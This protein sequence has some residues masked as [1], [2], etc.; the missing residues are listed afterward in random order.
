ESLV[1]VSIPASVK[2][3]GGYAFSNCTSLVSIGV[4]SNN[5]R[6]ATLDGVL[7]NKKM[8][9]LVQYPAGNQRSAYTV[10]A[11]VT[12]I[13]VA[14]FAYC[15]NL[16]AIEVDGANASYASDNGVLYNADMSTLIQYPVGNHNTSFA[17]PD[18]VTAIADYSFYNCTFLADITL[19]DSVASIGVYAFDN[20]AY[21]NNTANWDGNVLYI[22]NHLIKAKT[23]LSGSYTVK[24]GTVTVADYAF[25]SCSKLTNIVLDNS[26][27][28]IGT[29]I[30]AHCTALE[31]VTIGTGAV[32]IGNY[33]F[34]KCTA[35]TDVYYNSTEEDWAVIKVGIG[36][37]CLSA[38]TIH[39]TVPVIVEGVCGDDLT[40]VF[41]SVEGTLTISGTGEMYDYS[42]EYVG[43]ILRTTAPWKAY[44]ASVRSI[45][46]GDDVTSIGDYAFYNFES[47]SD[48][49]LDGSVTRIGNGAFEKCV[50]L[51]N[52]VI[53]DSVVTVGDTAFSGCVF[54]SSL[55]IGDSVTAIGDSAFEG[56]VSLKNVNLGSSVETVGAKA[57]K[58]CE[59]LAGISIPASLKTVGADA[60]VGCNALAGVYITD[61]AAWCGIGFNSEKSNPLTYAKKL[62][63][64]STFV[65][66]L[67]IPSSVKN[68]NNYA[69]YNC[70]S[71][72]TVNFGTSVKTIGSY[73]FY[74]CTGLGELT[75]PASVTAIGEKAF[76][77]YMGGYRNLDITIVCVENSYAHTY[78]QNNGFKYKIYGSCGDNLTWTFV[79]STGTLTILGEGDMYNY[80]N[81]VAPWAS[82]ASSVKS[83][84]IGNGVT[85]IG[86]Y[87]FMGCDALTSVNIPASVAKLG[88]GA[89]YE[90][91]ALKSVAIPES[92]ETI[93][94]Y[95]FYGCTSLVKVTLPVSVTTVGY[96]AFY[97][98]TSLAD[99]YYSGLATQWAEIFIDEYN[100]A[101]T[102]ANLHFLSP[103]IARGDCGDGVVWTLNEDGVL[104]VSGEGKMTDYTSESYNG[105][106]RTT[107]PWKI[108]ASSIK[109]VV[110]ESGVES[111]GTSAFCYCPGLESV[112]VADTVVSVGEDAFSNCTSLK[113]ITL[114]VSIRA[115]GN[116]AFYNTAYYNTNANWT[117]NVLYIGRHLIKAN[118][119]ISGTCYINSGTVTIAN[120][121]FA[122]CQSLTGVS[123]PSSVITIG[124]NAFAGCVSLGKVVIPNSVTRVGNSAFLDCAS[125]DSVTIG[126]SV[127]YIGSSAFAYCYSLTSISI[128]D[129]VTTIGDNAFEECSELADITLPDSLTSIGENA[130][131]Y[132]AYFNDS[133]NW[134]SQ[135]LYIGNHLI[136]AKR[137]LK[138]SYYIKDGTLTIADSA[139][140]GC[141]LLT[142]VTMPESVRDIGKKAFFNCTTFADVSYGGSEEQW[143]AIRIGEDNDPLNSAN[144]KYAS[145][146]L[147]GDDVTWS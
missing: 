76:Q 34:Y 86:D 8:T 80:E 140:Y 112:T 10:P 129:S 97:D 42:N 6:Y 57:F 132:T 122:N 11:S 54:L 51:K 3:I 64:D 53:G 5:Q 116:N 19:P 127:D 114:P 31:N 28:N 126:T 1:S 25:S 133:S 59:S 55:N 48:I 92:V 24:S 100:E 110:I 104:T 99:V 27:V 26:V 128:P 32:S 62:Y 94:Y 130:F 134:E 144:I 15:S 67:V 84:V 137:A 108:Y 102:S 13:G 33:A 139:F 85:G 88:A 18:S 4:D 120:N 45:F 66:D 115:I 142:S 121:A 65:T 16:E 109:S 103:I 39:Y 17:V 125:L 9:T 72:K 98:C 119:P 69:F 30:F 73:A 145:S 138:S 101:L 93:D 56:C 37:E 96:A 124:D 14:A 83:V 70:S 35:L 147:C 38:S 136:K 118:L 105:T 71:L 123:I 49:T 89:F 131:N 44:T 43:G 135:V 40:W 46:I 107:A 143:L 79:S 47:V 91:T 75:I 81:A 146:K 50:S 29:G 63:L 2:N 23:T 22:G 12:S 74:G 60:F 61:L 111:I 141:N 78:A 95:T 106:R 36:N 117:N 52:V 20:T 113:D 77:C 90:C 21:Y 68:I 87:A 7:Y 58:L 41:N 82:F